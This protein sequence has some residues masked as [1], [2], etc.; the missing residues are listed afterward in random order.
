MEPETNYDLEILTLSDAPTPQPR[1]AGACWG[2]G[3]ALGGKRE[4][5]PLRRHEVEHSGTGHLCP[6]FVSPRLVIDTSLARQ[7]FSPKFGG[8]Q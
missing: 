5:A 6:H 3:A 7:A 1:H 2:R 4:I 8:D